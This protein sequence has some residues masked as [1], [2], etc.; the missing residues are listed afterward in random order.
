MRTKEEVSP[1]ASLEIA[2]F[3]EFRNTSCSAYSTHSAVNYINPFQLVYHKQ[4]EK[5]PTLIGGG[6]ISS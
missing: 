5:A 2:K 3:A 6:L 1:L 4:N